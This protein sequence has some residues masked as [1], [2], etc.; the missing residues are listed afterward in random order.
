M[1]GKDIMLSVKRALFEEQRRAYNNR[2]FFNT[3]EIVIFMSEKAFW[4]VSAVLQQNVNFH[5]TS[6]QHTMFGCKVRIISEEGI[7]AYIGKECTIF[8]EGAEM[9]GGADNE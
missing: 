8:E 5:V 1:T 4:M 7:T 2:E 6:T 3:D 9:K